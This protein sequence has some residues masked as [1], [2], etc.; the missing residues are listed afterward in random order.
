MLNM[1]EKASIQPLS[2]ISGVIGHKNE[3]SLANYKEGD[4]NEQR[5]ISNHKLSRSAK[6]I[7]P[8]PS[9]SKC[10][11]FLCCGKHDDDK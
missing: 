10:W 6:H 1:L 5:L 7:Q 4:E 8:T 3:R 2:A 9:S 11:P